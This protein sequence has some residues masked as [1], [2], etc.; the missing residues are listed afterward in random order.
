MKNL[1]LLFISLF[2]ISFSSCD[3]DT[4]AAT[5]NFTNGNPDE[6]EIRIDNQSPFVMKNVE[7]NTGSNANTYDFVGGYG[8]SSFQSFF[9]AYPTVSLSFVVGEKQFD[10]ADSNYVHQN[11][12]SAAQYNLLVYDIDTIR[13]TFSFRLEK[14]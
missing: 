11:K 1:Y 3:T 2:Y 9:Y 12:L 5:P 14:Q 6:V 8:S 10:Y 7:V 13:L 4:D